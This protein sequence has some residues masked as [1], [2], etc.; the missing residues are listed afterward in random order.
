MTSSWV[1]FCI[2]WSTTEAAPGTTPYAVHP[3]HVNALTRGKL[4]YNLQLIISKQGTISMSRID[5]LKFSRENCLRRRP[6]DITSSITEILETVFF[7]HRPWKFDPLILY[8]FGY[9]IVV[10]Y[11]NTINIWPIWWIDLR[12]DIKTPKESWIMAF[13]LVCMFLWQRFR[14]HKI[15]NWYYLLIVCTLKRGF[16]AFLFS[17]CICYCNVCIF[18]QTTHTSWK[19][20]SLI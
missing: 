16:K 15:Q 12:V 5:I 6:Q 10:Y 11:I 9:L 14:P 17:K 7:K 2:K 20:M 3:F 18:K 8:S 1:D 4:G 19:M 13:K